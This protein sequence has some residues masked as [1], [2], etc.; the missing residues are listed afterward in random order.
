MSKKNW[1]KPVVSNLDIL[2]T[3]ASGSF[4]DWLDIV[5]KDWKSH[6]YGDPIFGQWFKEYSSQS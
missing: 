1:G 4:W 5:H 3:D 2:R 6:Q